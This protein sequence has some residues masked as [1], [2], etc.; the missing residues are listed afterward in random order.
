MRWILLLALPL[1]VYGNDGNASTAA[2]GIQ[3]IRE[4][5]ISMEKER[6][7]ISEKK[8]SVEY[9]FLNETDRDITTEVAFP[10]PPYD[11]KYAFDDKKYAFDNDRP[12]RI[13]NFHVWIEGR[14]IQYQ[15]EVKAMLGR[16]DYAAHL[17]Q[18]GI[19]IVSLGHFDLDWHPRRIRPFREILGS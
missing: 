15:S 18:L 13:D 16:V 17:R 7:V 10:I 14:E 1:A 5:R 2:G 12:E 3:L 9:E 11:K 4:P 19:D 6:L 8:V